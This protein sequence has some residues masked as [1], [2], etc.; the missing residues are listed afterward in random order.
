[1]TPY[2]KQYERAVLIVPREATCAYRT[3][4]KNNTISSKYRSFYFNE[5]SVYDAVR[6]SCAPK[7]QPPFKKGMQLLKFSI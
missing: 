4:A 1:M 5:K 3:S 6:C 7:V 2:P